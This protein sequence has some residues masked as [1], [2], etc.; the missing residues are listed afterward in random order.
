MNERKRHIR[1][2]KFFRRVLAP[3]LRRK[4]AYSY[5]V[6]TPLGEPYIVLANHNTDWDPLLLSLAFP[7]HMYY[8][9]SEHIFRKGWLSR[10]LMY[11]FAPISR[12]KGSADVM[13]VKK[14]VKALRSGANVGVFAEGNRSFNGRTG[15]IPSSIGKLVRMA[16]VPLVT[17]RITGGYFTSPRWSR[18][19]RRGQMN[20]SVAHIYSK[21]A[22]RAMTAEQINQAIAAEL[23]EDAYQTPE[24]VAYR[25]RARAEYLETALYICPLCNRIGT[26]HSEDDR[27]F[28]DCGLTLRYTETGRLT[29]SRVPF[30]TVAAWD[31]WQAEAFAA[32]CGAL[33]D[34]P[35]FTDAA[36]QL[37]RVNGETH[38]SEKAAQGD[39]AAY[40][41]RLEVGAYQWRYS[42]ISDM[43][44]YG[45]MTLV[46]TTAEGAHYEMLS[47]YPR[48][49]RK[50]LAI[51]QLCKE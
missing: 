47:P 2:Y 27:F 15:E 5:E 16:G 20:G 28:C 43:S 32:Y 26:L 22:L 14:V 40:R 49:A 3:Y 31:A 19:L 41:D 48:S 34:A 44:I 13:T 17:Y 33:L 7:A 51:Y 46:F 12:L 29:G 38:Q 21:E 23:W 24:Q 37:Y 39:A 4:F 11:Y 35:A 25:G 18:T 42:E 30:S 6:F 50:Y 36:Q 45:K 1:V 10:L 8:V 9:A